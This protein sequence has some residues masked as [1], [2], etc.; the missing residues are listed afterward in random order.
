MDPQNNSSQDDVTPN[1]LPVLNDKDVEVHTMKNDL[2]KSEKFVK[3]DVVDQSS[4]FSIMDSPEKKEE[5]VFP[6]TTQ[7][8]ETKPKEEI[9]RPPFPPQGESEKNK[10]VESEIKKPSPF[11]KFKRPKDI[12]PIPS[13]KTDSSME[14]FKSAL[15]KKSNNLEEIISE[16]NEKIDIPKNSDI[17]SEN[18]IPK[19]EL[20][21]SV[22]SLGKL[23]PK[24]SPVAPHMDIKIPNKKGG[25][26]KVVVFAFSSLVLVALLSFG[27]YYFFFKKEVGSVSP[28]DS[29]EIQE[30]EIV[31]IEEPVVEP[32]LPEPEPV[33]VPVV[34]EIQEP[35]VPFTLLSFDESVTT[36][37]N[38]VDKT[39]FLKSLKADSRVIIGEGVLT[40]HLFKVSNRDEKR[41]VV[42]KE[43]FDTLGIIIP[44]ILWSEISDVEF[45]SYKI[46]G[47]LRY[48]FIAKI[49]NKARV[50]SIMNDW[51]VQ[52]IID[53][54][55][56]YMGEPIVIPEDPR[57]SEN[58]YLD[59]T[60]KYINLTSP[61][62]SLDYA[63]S[64][65][66]LIITTSK[67]MIF[68]SIL[69]TQK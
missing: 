56:L 62:I 66:Y 18:I 13:P 37:T 3:K 65:N 6:K 10:M 40:R 39:E 17:K 57:F 48:G 61:E 1:D 54:K 5:A 35:V 30:P 19:P 25:T 23:E 55:Q 24:E 51:E 22:A 43:L 27:G 50:L 21:S 59:F 26:M 52:S 4:D 41:Y 29:A 42:N 2:K 44:E 68:A 64:N 38:V 31:K 58:T 20:E 45:V 28:S 60:K 69:K 12:A 8:Q 9:P 14:S 11:D 16:K 32:P 67:D 46:D 33:V 36:S 53:L 49:S 47:I 7:T 15:P 63:V 34:K